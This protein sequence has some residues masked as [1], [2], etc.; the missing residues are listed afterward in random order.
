MQTTITIQGT[1][2]GSC[3]ALIEEVSLE[4]PGITACTI[5]DA[6][7][8]TVIQH[9]GPLDLAELQHAISEVGDYII[10]QTQR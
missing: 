10:E 8:K 5:D 1:H 4:Q 6:T 2:C 9:D 3:K 7:G